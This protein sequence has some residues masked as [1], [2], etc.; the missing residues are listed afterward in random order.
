MNGCL[1]APDSVTTELKHNLF[2]IFAKLLDIPSP[3]GEDRSR[4]FDPIFAVIFF[5]KLPNLSLI[6]S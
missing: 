5:N 3:Q 2:L 1:P 6:L 4:S